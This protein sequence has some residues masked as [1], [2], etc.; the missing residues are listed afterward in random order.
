MNRLNRCN[1][2]ILWKSRGNSY[3]CNVK[4][5]MSYDG[6]CTSTTELDATCSRH[7]PSPFNNTTDKV[8]A[9]INGCRGKNYGCT[10]DC[11]R[12]VV[13]A[14]IHNRRYSRGGI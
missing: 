3:Y 4:K 6:G 8:I 13:Y 9:T 5:C 12:C 1:S 2:V 11:T 14:Y 7:S 10:K